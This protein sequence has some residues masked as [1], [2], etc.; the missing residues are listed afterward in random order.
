MAE[1]VLLHGWPY[2]IQT[3]VE[4]ALL[5]AAAGYRVIVPYLRGSGT[6]R[7]PS[8][9]AIRNGQQSA[10]GTD[11]IA[12]MD[13]LGIPQAVIAGCD[14]GGAPSPLPETTPFA[15]IAAF[16]LWELL[17]RPHLN[18]TMCNSAGRSGNHRDGLSQSG[19]FDDG[20]ARHWQ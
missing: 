1:W 4:V 17:E 19:G 12:L 2:D 13:A 6:T 5:L 20:K 10:F 11:T 9:A 8:A 7:F 16:V 18:D 14:W 15:V 3:Y